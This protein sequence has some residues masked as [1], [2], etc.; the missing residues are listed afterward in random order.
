MR[1]LMRPLKVLVLGVRATEIEQVLRKQTCTQI[2]SIS[3]WIELN[4][5]YTNCSKESKASLEKYDI[6]WIL[7]KSKLPLWIMPFNYSVYTIYT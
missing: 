6:I 1:F 3:D 4:S 2:I 5:S 7:Y